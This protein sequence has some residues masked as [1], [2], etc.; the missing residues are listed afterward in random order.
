[1]ERHRT[2]GICTLNGSKIVINLVIGYLFF[3]N[4]FEVFLRWLKRLLLEDLASQIA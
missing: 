2:F 3:P 4:L 1:V